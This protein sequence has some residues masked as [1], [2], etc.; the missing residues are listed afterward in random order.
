MMAEVLRSKLDTNIPITVKFSYYD[1]LE[2]L[3]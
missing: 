2:T 3:L 1:K